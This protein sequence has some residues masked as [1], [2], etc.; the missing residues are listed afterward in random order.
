MPKLKIADK[1][2]TD[3][4]LPKVPLV[5]NGKTYHLVFTFAALR[6][7]EREF[8][9][10]GTPINIFQQFDFDN[11]SAEKMTALLYAAIVTDSPEL[12]IADVPSLITMRDIPAI[13]EAVAVAFTLSIT[14]PDQLAK[15]A[16]AG[17]DPLEVKD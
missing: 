14:P 16:K 3:P 13:R 10:M 6:I 2:A 8:A 4:A 15:H 7:A 5:L 9:K 17:V 11:M 12:T 1:A